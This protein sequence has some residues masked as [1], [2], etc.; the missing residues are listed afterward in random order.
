MTQKFMNLLEKRTL[1]SLVKFYD[2]RTAVSSDDYLKKLIISYN[3]GKCDS[4]ISE[5]DFGKP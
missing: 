5:K 1:T 3:F 2:N 4:H